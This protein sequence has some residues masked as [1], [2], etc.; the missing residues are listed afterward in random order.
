M[1]YVIQAVL[2]T[3][4][5]YY[6]SQGVNYAKQT[7]SFP[8]FMLLM[9]VCFGM[10]YGYARFS[11]A[12]DDQRRAEEEIERLRQSREPRLEP[13]PSRDGYSPD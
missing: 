8:G 7:M 1:L 12:R 5:V 10:I 6:A 9:A 11:D 13:P 2:L 3:V 4:V